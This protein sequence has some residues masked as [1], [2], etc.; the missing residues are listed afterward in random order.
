MQNKNIN[1]LSIVAL[2]FFVFNLN[3]HFISNRKILFVKHKLSLSSSSR[4]H[5][6]TL[7]SWINLIINIDLSDTHYTYNYTY[8]FI[9]DK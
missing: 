7:T 8:K 1:N 5:C 3:Q 6:G 2:N 4:N 9:G